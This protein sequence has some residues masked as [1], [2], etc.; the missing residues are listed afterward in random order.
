MENL[1]VGIIC[2]LILGILIRSRYAVARWLNLKYINEASD[3]EGT[4]T[5]LEKLL[6]D[7]QYRLDHLDDD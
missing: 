6:K 7:T 2:I 1:I 3:K 5:T 4:R